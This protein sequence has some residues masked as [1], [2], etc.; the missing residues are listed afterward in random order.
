MRSDPKAP[1]ASWSRRTATIRTAGIR[2][3][4][5]VS[6]LAGVA[7]S[8]APGP[9]QRPGASTTEVSADL[10]SC[11]QAAKAEADRLYVFSF[12]FPYPLGWNGGRQIGYTEWRQ[13]FDAMKSYEESRLAG[14]CMRGKGYRASDS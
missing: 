8:C 10:D 14:I 12:P 11:Q 6:L 7:A 4:F 9:R 2:K 5:A 3:A 13:R 1:R